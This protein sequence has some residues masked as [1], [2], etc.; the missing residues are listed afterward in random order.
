[1]YI[2]KTKKVNVNQAQMAFLGP[3]FKNFHSG[4]KQEKS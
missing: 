4:N 3:L 2:E 1:M